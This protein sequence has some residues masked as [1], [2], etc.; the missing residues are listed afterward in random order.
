V[1]KLLRAAVGYI[2]D[3]R[4]DTGQVLSHRVYD[5]HIAVVIEPGYKYVIGLDELHLSEPEATPAAA[6]LATDHNLN[7]TTIVG[8]G[9]NGRITVPDV[10]EA[11]DAIEAL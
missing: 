6:R 10:Q 1:D 4:D 8:T 3:R 2:Q 11:K 7:L 9:K 5:D